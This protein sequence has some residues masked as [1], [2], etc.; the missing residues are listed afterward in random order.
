PNDPH[1]PISGL[2]EIE[3]THADSMA[4]PLSP[5]YTASI[6]AVAHEHGVPLHVDGARFFNAVV[7]LGVDPQALAG[8]G[9]SVSF[10]LSTGLSCPLPPSSTS[11]S[12]C[13]ARTSSVP[14]GPAGS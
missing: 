6:A 14:S 12:T 3:N 1:N 2:V 7:A 5:D 4:Q 9:D 8:P 10:C 11:R 13:M